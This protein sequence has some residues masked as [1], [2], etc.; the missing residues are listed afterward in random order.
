MIENFFIAVWL[1]SYCLIGALLVQVI[2]G[3]ANNLSNNKT[4]NVKQN[5]FNNNV[6]NST[7]RIK[8][9]QHKTRCG[10]TVKEIS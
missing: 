4:K 2:V 1:V 3:T 7:V 9:V 6:I 8:P 5:T 10:F